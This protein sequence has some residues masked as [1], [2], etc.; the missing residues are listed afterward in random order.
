MI[1]RR[2][3]CGLQHSQARNFNDFPT[4]RLWLDGPQDV[5]N[6]NPEKFRKTQSG[7]STHPLIAN[8]FRPNE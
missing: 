6:A 7:L 3:R 8:T 2:S 4:S 1:R 5:Y